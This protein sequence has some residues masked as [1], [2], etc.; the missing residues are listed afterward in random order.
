MKRL[1]V[2]FLLMLSTL[3]VADVF[4]WHNE[5]PTF[6]FFDPEDHIIVGGDYAVRKA[7]DSLDVAYTQSSVLPADLSDYDAVF[8]LLGSFCQS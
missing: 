6:Y 8:V 4:I 5:N 2:I 3:A 7:L 1:L